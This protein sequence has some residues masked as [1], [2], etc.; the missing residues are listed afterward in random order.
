MSK[1]LISLKVKC[2]YCKQSLMDYTTFLNAKPSIKLH[3]DVKGKH[4]V[5]HLC[6]TYGCY[7][8]SSNVELVDNEIARLFCSHCKKELAT[9]INCEV[10]GAPIVDFELEKGGNVHVC[11]RIGCQKHYV[12]FEDIYTTLTN[13]Y[14]EYDYGSRDTD[15]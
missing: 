13:F 8:K 9:T 1:N 15:F 10:C 5:I 7:E 12:S 2:P 4:G 6:S 11:S 3:I 14:Q